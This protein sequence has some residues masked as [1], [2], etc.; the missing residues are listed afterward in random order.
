MM[1]AKIIFYSFHVV[2]FY[3]KYNPSHWSYT[4]FILL[5][6]KP[7]TVTHYTKLHN[8]TQKIFLNENSKN[9]LFSIIYFFIVHNL[10]NLIH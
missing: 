3:T 8:K 6:T 2:I 4:F 5:Q 1:S 10:H 7:L 9:I